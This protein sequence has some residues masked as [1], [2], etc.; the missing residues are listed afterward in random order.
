[1]IGEKSMKKK[2]KKVSGSRVQVSGT[3]VKGEKSRNVRP[4]RGP[5]IGD[6]ARLS[7]KLAT[8]KSP[9][10]AGRNACSTSEERQRLVAILEAYSVSVVGFDA[11]RCDAYEK[12]VAG[13]SLAELERFYGLL[14]GP[15]RG[16]EEIISQ[17]PRWSDGSKNK[18]NLPHRTTL[19][20][21][22]ER[23]RVDGVIRERCGSTNR[24]T[25]DESG[26]SEEK[27]VSGAIRTLGQEL[28]RAKVDG[29]PV[30]ENLK[31][32]DRLLKMAGLRIK[33]RREKRSE[34][35][36]EWE[37]QGRP[38]VKAESK[39]RK[40]ETKQP[41]RQETPNE[42]IKR[43]YGK[44]PFVDEPEISPKSQVQG[45][46][47]EAKAESEKRPMTGG[48]ARPTG[49]NSNDE[50]RMTHG[51]D[52]TDKTNNATRVSA[53]GIVAETKSEESPQEQP[54]EV[55]QKPAWL[56]EQER[57]QREWQERCARQN[58]QLRDQASEYEYHHPS[59]MAAL[60]MSLDK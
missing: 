11:L 44:N 8:G 42:M 19:Q 34:A 50:A 41:Q 32:V 22:K 45:P 55:A 14:F 26:P 53:A 7:E 9:E 29:K 47:P 20:D 5:M 54:V 17:C 46:K 60:W 13:Q 30:S 3:N 27:Y 33:E 49:K 43:I 10:P 48:N 1:M 15:A 28:M 6:N 38:I 37:R 24:L 40:A 59:S 58:A 39:K 56:E 16:F 51:T 52:K 23:I 4:A 12:D 18:G 31:L 2:I 35:R 25:E 36:F 21:I 57:R